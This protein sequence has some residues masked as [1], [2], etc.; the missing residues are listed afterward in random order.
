MPD[1]SGSQAAIVPKWFGLVVAFTVV[2]APLFGALVVTLPL[3]LFGSLRIQGFYYSVFAALYMPLHVIFGIRLAYVRY[4]KLTR[5]GPVSLAQA[6]WGGFAFGCLAPLVV[7]AGCALPFLALELLSSGNRGPLVT[8]SD[9]LA[10]V[11]FLGG[12]IAFFGAFGGPLAAVSAAWFLNKI[13][14]R[15]KDRRL[16]LNERTAGVE[17][18][19]S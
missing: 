16:S 11:M 2:L 4:F 12:V 6:A 19:R 5:S 3:A 15:F 18:A 8:A 1:H 14:P 7:V 10:W 13:D 9:F 17:Q